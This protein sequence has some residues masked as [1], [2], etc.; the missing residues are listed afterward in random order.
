MLFGAVGCGSGAT[1]SVPKPVAHPVDAATAKFADQRGQGT[2]RV[3]VVDNRFRP[4]LLLV[5]PGTKVIWTNNGSITHNV[6]PSEDDEFT[7]VGAGD[8]GPGQSFSL[9]FSSVGDYPYYCSLHGTASLKGQW[10]A[11]RVVR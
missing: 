2:V 7:G 11:V 5:S 4:Q 8:F 9:T 6:V 1:I 3:S 10:G